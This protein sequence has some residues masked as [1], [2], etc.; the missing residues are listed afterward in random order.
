[1]AQEE[2]E[3]ITGIPLLVCRDFI[4]LLGAR[5]WRHYNES[6]LQSLK[7]YSP[8]F[9]RNIAPPSSWWT[10][11]PELWVNPGDPDAWLTALRWCQVPST[12][13]VHSMKGT[14]SNFR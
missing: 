3:I 1:V 14:E 4:I 11:K 8:T 5:L 12:I 13:L 2:M 6:G 9:W 10:S 7:K